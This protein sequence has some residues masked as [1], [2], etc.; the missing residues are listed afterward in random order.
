MFSGGYKHQIDSPDSS[1]KTPA[2]ISPFSPGQ[3]EIFSNSGD[4]FPMVIDH[5]ELSFVK[6]VR[7][8][9]VPGI[10]G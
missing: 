4:P 8:Q 5:G 10:N 1:P 6:K 2:K 7:A 9:S 3:K